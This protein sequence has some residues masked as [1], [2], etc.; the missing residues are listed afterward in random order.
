MEDLQPCDFAHNSLEDQKKFVDGL[1]DRELITEDTYNQ[2][3]H[4]EHGEE[5][6]FLTMASLYPIFHREEM[7][8]LIH[9]DDKMVEAYFQTNKEAYRYPAH[10]KLSM[11]VING[12][13]NSEDKQRAL[14]K[15]QKAYDELKPSFFSFRKAK[16]FAEVARNYS[17]D[18]ETASKGGRLEVD[19]YECRNS[20]EYMLLHGFHKQIFALEPGDIS[21]IF[22]Y[23]NNYYIVQIREMETRKQLTFDEVR[24]KV[25]DD[26]HAVKHK[27]IMENWEDMLLKSAGFE[28]YDRVLEDTLA[29]TEELQKNA[30]S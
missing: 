12:G 29:E 27:K 21:D 22:E 28:V 5:I 20:I 3:I 26:L 11:I 16:D 1:I 19:I 9:I 24:Q 10:A 7:Q 25:K 6:E 13:D 8:K 14:D 17:E 18:Q 4:V 30:E 15:A 23:E 2:M